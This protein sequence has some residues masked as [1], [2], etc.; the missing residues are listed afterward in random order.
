M[1][2]KKYCLAICVICVTCMGIGGIDHAQAYT[3]YEKLTQDD[4]TIVKTSDITD[5]IRQGAYNP[6]QNIKGL[7]NQGEITTFQQAKGDTMAF[8][9]RLVN[10][11]LGII[12]L[13]ALVYLMYH[14]FQMLT[15]A[16]D[17]TKF[18]SGS[19]AIRAATIALLGIGF[20]ALIVNTIFYL[21]SKFLS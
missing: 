17:E 9:Q 14:G 18:K 7:Y 10:W 19:K 2:M 3:Y 15:A 8:I 13:V 5:P 12:G 4:Q 16:G 11:F 6:G 1:W 20:S 21:I